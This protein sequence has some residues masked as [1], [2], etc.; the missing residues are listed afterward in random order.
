MGRAETRQRCK[1]IFRDNISKAQFNRRSSMVN[2]R[3]ES[4]LETGKLNLYGFLLYMIQTKLKFKN[5]IPNKV[6]SA[7]RI[8][9][10]KIGKV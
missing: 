7:N 1:D 2:H 10:V 6:I 8:A 3:F 9:L 5:Y 4:V